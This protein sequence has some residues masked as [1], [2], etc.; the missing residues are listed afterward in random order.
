[1]RS[2][3]F[4]ICFFSALI[5]VVPASHADSPES[6]RSILEAS[7]FLKAPESIPILEKSLPSAGEL[8]PY[9]VVELARRYGETAN[10][11]KVESL[12]AEF[13][14][15]SSPD[16]TDTEKLADQI[17]WWH[18]LALEKQLNASGAAAVAE[19]RIGTGRVADAAVYFAWFRNASSGTE[20]MVERFDKT[21]PDLKNNDRASFALSRYLSGLCAIREGDW[22][23]AVRSLS[24]FSPSDEKL[25]PE[26]APWSRYYRSWALYRLGKWKDSVTAFASYLD[27]WPNHERAWQA[28]TAASLAALL[29]GTDALPFAESAVQL[30]SSETDRASSGLLV[31]SILFDRK[32][33]AEAESILA[34]IADGSATKGLTPSAPRALFTLAEISVRLKKQDEAEKRWLS[35]I[36]RFP[37]DALAEESLYRAAEMRYLG[38]NWARSAE[39]FTQYRQQYPQGKFLEA[40]LRCGGEAL[41]MNGSVD[42]AI[43][44]WEDLVKKY[45]SSSSAPRTLSDLVDAYRSK[46]DYD[47]AIAAAEKYRD[48]YPSEAK[49]EGIDR[50]LADLAVLKKGGEAGTAA[51]AADWEKSGRAKTP[52]G[53]AS[54]LA[55]AK[56]YLAD[57]GTRTEAKNILKEITAKVPQQPG[58]VAPSEQSVFAAALSLYGSMC[59]NDGD[60]RTASRTLLA[61]GKWYASM[62]G[63]R[64]AEAL[65]GAVDCFL[66]AGLRADAAK[67]QETLSSTWPD[68]VWTKRAHV[69]MEQ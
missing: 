37:N 12:C 48:R 1:M 50:T 56:K 38:K 69:L 40:S 64:S 29:S 35:V 28:A 65:Y 49:A 68:S 59:R 6:A 42:L 36:A 5:L 54:G 8:K 3:F 66:Q 23:C 51:L 15:A 57:Y 14:K 4:C 10:W 53:R 63:E 21:F 7:R 67:T 22:N 13:E 60:Y 30:A 18:S 11:P 34:G 9:Y 26:L 25:F 20:P 46:G 27:A 55:L 58:Q 44:W 62:D 61:A 52:E 41:S 45:P 2:R 47:G 39:L 19:K 33:Y 24:D 17:A 32:K 31:A 43:L 16:G